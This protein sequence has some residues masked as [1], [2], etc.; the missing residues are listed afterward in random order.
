MAEP[1]E[2]R[3]DRCAIEFVLRLFESPH[4]THLDTTREKESDRDTWLVE[5][6]REG[7]AHQ[8]ELDLRAGRL[9]VD[10]RSDSIRAEVTEDGYAI[11]DTGYATAEAAAQALVDTLEER[12]TGLE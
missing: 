1:F 2:P 5:F 3:M 10:W 9:L 8:A 12:A 11:G 6:E 4:F 7:E